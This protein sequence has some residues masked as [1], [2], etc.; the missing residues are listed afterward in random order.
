[1]K[2]VNSGKGQET[3][4]SKVTI[5]ERNKRQSGETMGVGQ[6]VKEVR[7]MGRTWAFTEAQV[8]PLQGTGQRSDRIR[9]LSERIILLVVLYG[10]ER[11]G[12]QL[13]CSLNLLPSHSII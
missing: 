1:M 8:L 13:V 11:N 2:S 5:E 4:R 6:I 12:R 3:R 7:A 10:T 9:L